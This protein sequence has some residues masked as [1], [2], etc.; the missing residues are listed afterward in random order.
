MAEGLQ[1]LRDNNSLDKEFEDL[2]NL[3]L[4]AELEKYK[5]K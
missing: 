1:D 2:N 3:D 5:N 4:D